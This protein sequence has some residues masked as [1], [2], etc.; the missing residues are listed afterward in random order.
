[1]SERDLKEMLEA[2]EQLKPEF[3]RDPKARVRFL[4]DA[5]TP[6]S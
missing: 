4:I 3:E 5:L 6:A 1:M 2:L